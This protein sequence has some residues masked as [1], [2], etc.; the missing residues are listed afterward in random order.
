M[1]AAVSGGSIVHANVSSVVSASTKSAMV[2]SA[3]STAKAPSR[4]RIPE[5]SGR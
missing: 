1:K 2:A 4:M 5:C 3:V